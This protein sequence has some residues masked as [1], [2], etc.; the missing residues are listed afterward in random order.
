[1]SAESKLFSKKTLYLLPQ[2]FEY[3]AF[4]VKCKTQSKVHYAHGVI[5]KNG[6]K[7][8]RGQCQNCGCEAY[9]ILPDNKHI[10]V[11]SLVRSSFVKDAL[12]YLGAFSAAFGLGI[13]IAKAIYS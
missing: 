11:K 5:F 10:L 8:M 6:R 1:M 12:L 9:K 3:P 7:A 2:K 13:L 4:C